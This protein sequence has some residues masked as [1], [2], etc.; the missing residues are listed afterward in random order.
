AGVGQIRVLVLSSTRIIVGKTGTT[1]L[2]IA[3]YQ[4]YTGIPDNTYSIYGY[5]PAEFEGN[6][7]GVPGITVPMGYAADGTPMGLEF[8]GQ[9]D[10]EGPL[11]GMAYD[12]EQHTE[13]RAD[14]NLDA[15]SVPAPPSF[16]L[17][18]ISI[19]VGLAD[20]ARRRIARRAA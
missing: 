14:P 7:L 15:L 18:A 5:L 1:R 17:G 2:Y 9:F 20:Y 3:P 13:F 10:G 4:A 19:V 11:I 12:Y 16:V 6:I 8:M